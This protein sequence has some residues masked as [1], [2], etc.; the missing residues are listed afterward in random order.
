MADG[1]LDEIGPGVRGKATLGM[2]SDQQRPPRIPPTPVVKRAFAL[3]SRLRRL[4]DAMLPPQGVA[5]ER[6]FLLAEIKMLGVICE[7]QIPEAID[8]GATRAHTIADRV[9]AQEDATERVLRFLA[10]RGWF[11]RKRD[12]S[13]RLNARS[14]ALR[15]HDPQAL[16]DWV[17]FMAADWHWDI[18]NHAIR[19]VRDGQS[20]AAA[21]LG[22]PF[23]DWVHDDNPAAGATFDGAM[24]SL[25]S[26]AGPLVVKAVE[27]D[28]V[29]SI[30]DV[31]GGTGRL[32]RA[33]LDAAPAARGTVFDLPE[34]VS[35]AADVLADLPAHRWSTAVGSFFE[36][37]VIPTGDDRYVM[38]AI[39]HDW[40]DEQAG[41]IL[42]N[43]RTAMSPDSRLWVID[44]ILE[45]SERD[46][47]SKAVDMLMLTVTEGG[48][49]RTQNEW[50]RLFAASGFRIESQTQLPLLIW[51]FTL[52][53]A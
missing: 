41:V 34:V 30:C 52:T 28:G 26:V 8:E 21:A 5:A 1:S 42:D 13:Y 29:G 11:V 24:R 39:L 43:V 46:D 53:P 47:L 33:L 19:P 31:G 3:R 4:A 17:R 44:S 40:P 14:R 49:E 37:G 12:G 48:R 6:T 22:K 9:G 18:W 2:P 27:L 36:H 51:V 38:Q 35:G 10:S 16:R 50:D 25:S 15:S 20:A 23:F 45:P 32:L 7:L